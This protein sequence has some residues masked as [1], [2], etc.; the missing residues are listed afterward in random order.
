MSF[1]VQ[2]VVTFSG[3]KRRVNG[4]DMI[5]VSGKY[6]PE[7]TL[8]SFKNSQGIES[9]KKLGE[10]DNNDERNVVSSGNDFTDRVSI[11]LTADHICSQ[12]FI[13]HT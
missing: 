1:H 5:H 2:T 9:L 12:L 8:E 6:L 10:D 3:K 11:F 4:D 13:K 7:D